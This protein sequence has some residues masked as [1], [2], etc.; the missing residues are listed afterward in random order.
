MGEED[1]DSLIGC[2][3]DSEVLPIVKNRRKGKATILKKN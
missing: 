1:N 3:V 2:I